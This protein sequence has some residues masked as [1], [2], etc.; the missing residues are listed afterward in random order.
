MRF[1]LQ[2]S[3]LNVSRRILRSSSIFGRKAC[4]GYEYDRLLRAGSFTA[5]SSIGC[6]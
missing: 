6:E 2:V 5:R 3:P 1:L 4:I